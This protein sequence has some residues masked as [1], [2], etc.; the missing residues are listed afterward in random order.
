METVIPVWQYVLA[1]IFIFFGAFVQGAIGLGVAIVAVPLLL[2]LNQAFVPVPIMLIS[3][4]LMSSLLYTNRQSI[5]LKNISFAV[6]GYLP[7]AIAAG[8]LITRMPQ[9][10]LSITFAIIIIIAVL[11][12]LSG[13]SIPVTN[14]NTFAVSSVAG[15]MGTITSI[16]GPP[17]ALL[18][19]NQ[20]GP[21]VR[22]N[23][24]AI[25]FAAACITNTVNLVTGRIHTADLFIALAM[26]PGLIAGLTASKYFARILDRGFFKPAI[27]TLCLVSAAMS[28]IRNIV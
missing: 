7:G 13:K 18:Y 19:Q 5:R 23:L 24:A 10:S 9:Q 11:L 4:I 12:S 22:A 17:L 21:V 27:L 15:V 26:L 14:F 16:A 2:L 25:F 6:L 1:N 3:I 8:F 28:L 20:S